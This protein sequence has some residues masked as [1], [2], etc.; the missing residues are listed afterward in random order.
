M[1]NS[2]RLTDEDVRTQYGQQP[3]RR[4]S[5]RTYWSTGWTSTG[6]TQEAQGLKVQQAKGGPLTTVY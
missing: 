6:A 5:Q 3:L 1:K 4:E 2:R